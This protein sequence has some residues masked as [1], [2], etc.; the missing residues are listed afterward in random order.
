[1]SIEEID[2]ICKI[3]NILLINKRQEDTDDINK[4]M[5]AK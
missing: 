3:A 2:N 4:T 5:D 1:M